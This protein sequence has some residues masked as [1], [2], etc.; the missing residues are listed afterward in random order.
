MASLVPFVPS[1]IELKHGLAQEYSKAAGNLETA[2]IQ[3]D[4]TTHGP[5]GSN[6]GIKEVH[7]VRAVPL[8]Y[9][10]RNRIVP[11]EY[12]PDDTNEGKVIQITV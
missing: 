4:P 2:G 6:W 9:V 10:G 7:S 12:F 5:S 3:Q 1:E 11:E 8:V